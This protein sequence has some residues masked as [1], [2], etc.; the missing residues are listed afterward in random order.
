VAGFFW[1]RS[2]LGPVLVLFSC[3][4]KN[5]EAGC[6]NIKEPSVPLVYIPLD[7]LKKKVKR[8]KRQKL[9][10]EVGK[11]TSYR[12]DHF[13]LTRILLLS[14]FRERGRGVPGSPLEPFSVGFFCGPSSVG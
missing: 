13:R 4:L 3:G 11:S 9:E 1:G 2:P 14:Q 8:R 5:G 6:K 10:R 12:K 7:R